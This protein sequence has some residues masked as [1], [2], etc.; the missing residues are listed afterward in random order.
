LC[1]AKTANVSLPPRSIKKSMAALGAAPFVAGLLTVS[2]SGV[3]PKSVAVPPSAP[4]SA[5]QAGRWSEWTSS[6]Q[7][8]GANHADPGLL[9]RCD[10]T[11]RGLSAAAQR[12]A[13]HQAATG[14]LMEIDEVTFEMRLAGVPHVWPRAW[15]ALG[16]GRS[17]LTVLAVDALADLKPIPRRARTGEWIELEAQLLDVATRAEVVV[18]G[19]RGA[20]RTVPT[21]LKDGRVRARFPLGEPGPWLVQVLPTLKGGPRPV[22][23]AA[24]FVDQP[25]PTLFQSAEVPGEHAGLTL[26]AAPPAVLSMLN[27]AR[28]AEGLAPLAFDERLASAAAAH[29]VAMRNTRRVAH[30]VGNGSPTQRIQALGLEP[31]LAGENVAHASSLPRAHRALWASPSHRSNLL[32]PRFT[33]VGIGVAEDSDGS[34]WVCQVFAS[35]M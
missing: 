15:S 3:A 13:E 6:P 32:H 11:D 22:L 5:P 23:E 33:H 21:Q 28:E 25:P 18:L 34:Y 10:G 17:V 1:Q 20:P 14:E 8:G 31:A 27:A 9:R 7:P 29:S 16:D 30:D 26:P 12:L 35:F 2:C 24:L 19:P 4:K